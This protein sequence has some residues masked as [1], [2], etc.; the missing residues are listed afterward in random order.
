MGF[1]QRFR[2]QLLP[3]NTSR[4]ERIKLQTRGPLNGSCS[5]RP[6]P[7]GHGHFLRRMT[8]RHRYMLS[9]QPL[10]ACEYLPFCSCLLF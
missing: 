3:L 10:L 4:T 1:R 8:L 5:H 2:C 7:P 6:H 9:S